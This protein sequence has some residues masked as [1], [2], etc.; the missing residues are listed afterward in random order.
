VDNETEWARHSPGLAAMSFH[1]R[2]D[3]D[4]AGRDDEKL[5]STP[6]ARDWKGVPGDTYNSHNL[7]RDISRLVAEEPDVL[8]LPA[9]RAIRGGSATETLNL[10]QPIP[11]QTEKLPMLPTP[12]AI[13]G[14]SATE[15]LNLLQPIPEQTEKLPMLP[16]PTAEEA[17]TLFPTPGASDGNGGK[18]PKDLS[19]TTRASG[20][21]RQVCLPEAVKLLPTPQS[22]D[23]TGG[24]PAAVER[25]RGYGAN[26][27]DVA[28]AGLF[29][30]GGDDPL[31]PTPM[32]KEIGLSP[33]QF[34]SWAD[35]LKG[36][37]YNGNGRGK[38]LAV[39]V[40][41]FKL[42]DA[43][44]DKDLGE[45]VDDIL[46]TPKTH[47][48][49]DCPSERE[50]N[51]PDLAAVTHHFPVEEQPQAIPV[52]WGKYDPAVRRWEKL[53]RPAPIPTEPNK[54]GNPR[55][56][57]PF[58]EWMMGWPEGWVTDPE[59][60]LPRTAQLKIIGNG[61]CPQQAYSAITELL[62]IHASEEKMIQ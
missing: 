16:T 10:L 48:L 57:A 51:S 18:S 6:Q 5:F 49:G 59:I 42:T 43:V 35:R 31:L 14:G 54:N 27:N 34:D 7:A 41:R 30:Q 46:P 50:R 1:L 4:Q 58:S 12:R 25:G 55:L 53:T 32:A 37:G 39:E 61:V 52:L 17:L 8:L 28:A 29:D 62:S 26:M 3:D 13:R 47:Q 36:K 56:A 23:A 20:A 60:G 38:S 40:Q 24:K 19:A 33:E 44:L 15:T 9:P 2:S 21:K 22:R 11:E 45:N